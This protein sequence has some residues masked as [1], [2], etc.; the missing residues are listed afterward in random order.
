[1]KR[2]YYIDFIKYDGWA[3]YK[4]KTRNIIE[5]THCGNAPIN[6]FVFHSGRL[7]HDSRIF[8]IDQE[9]NLTIAGKEL[10]R[11]LLRLINE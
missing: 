10:S 1:M 7:Q 6:A 2:K 11:L 4:H 5:C 8:N 3:S 9:I